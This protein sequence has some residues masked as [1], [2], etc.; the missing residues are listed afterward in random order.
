MRSPQRLA[1]TAGVLYLL[2]GLF[3]GFAEGGVEPQMY[4]AGDAAGTS[5]NLVAHAGLVRLAVVSDLVNQVVFVVLALTLYS[6]L[7]DVRH[8]VARAMVA[9]VVV[10]AAVASMSAV[11]ELEGLRVAT[12]AVDLSP[13]GAQGAQ[14]VALLLLDAQH[15]GLLAAQVFFGLW[16]IPLAY[17]ALASRRFPRPLGALLVVAGACYVVDV[18]TAVLVPAFNA[19]IHLSVVAPCT[20]A[21]ELWMVGYLLTVGVRSRESVGADER[22]GLAA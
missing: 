3:G 11:L 22:V 21:A 14:A 19:S 16:L 13:L 2:V 7:K 8:T 10:A 17:L 20:T 15:Y 12:G 1:R 4:V 9:L 6:L 5:A 18:V